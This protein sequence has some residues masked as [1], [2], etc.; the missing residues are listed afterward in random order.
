MHGNVLNNIMQMRVLKLKEL[1]LIITTLLWHMMMNNNI[2][3][4]FE[5]WV[6]CYKSLILSTNKDIRAILFNY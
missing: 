2:K 3:E 4:L 5:V 6:C 1:M